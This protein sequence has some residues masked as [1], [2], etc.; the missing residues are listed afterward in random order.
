M[1]NTILLVT[2][3]FFSMTLSSSSNP[4]HF[5]VELIH[6]DS[7]H[8]P[9]Y[10]PQ[11]TLTDRL[12][13]SFLR[14]ISRSHRFNNHPQT[15]LQSGLI[16]A[17]G[18]FFMSITIGTPPINVL[19]IAD[20]GSDLT[21]VQCKPCQQCYKENGPIFDSKQ[22]SSYKSEPCDSRNCNALS[23]T[24]RG[25]D[26]AK[27]VCKYRYTYG[28]RSFTRGDVATE[29]VSIGSAS[30]SPVSFPGTVFGCGYNNGGNFDE[31]GSGIIGL[32]GGNLSLISQL[33]SSISN[34]FSYCLSHKSSTMNGT[35]VINL[36]TSSIPSGA[37]NVSNVVSTPLV[38]KEPQ[39]YYY[40]TLEAISVGNTKIPYTS[41][42]YYPNDD[43]VSSAATKGNIIIDSGTTL[44][45][46]ESGFYDKFGAA[47]EESVTGAKRVSDPQGLLSHCFKSG[48][49]EIGLPEITV[50]FSGADVRLSALNA[51]VKMSEDMVCLSMIPTN[52]VAIYGNFAQ[53]DF[54]VGYDLE[55]RRVSFQRMDCSADL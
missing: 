55:T 44:T 6:R 28:D 18:E 45:L 54:L 43:G 10:N 5:T 14:S 15:D 3:F 26:E 4:K 25:C 48:S 12:H 52:E 23:T 33:G 41:S 16:G 37:S 1:A 17:G 53:M 40:L 22:S 24:E 46:L 39:T 29:T 35:S 7:P 30:G 31:T 49:A 51:F 2:L 32:G 38:D 13:S 9:L 20:T 11:T 21:W 50:H 8:S 36:G 42:M 19:A 47:V 27:G 34:K